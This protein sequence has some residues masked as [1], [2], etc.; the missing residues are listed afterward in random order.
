[1]N[2]LRKHRDQHHRTT[3]G[4]RNVLSDIIPGYTAPMQL[5]SSWSTN[6]KSSSRKRQQL[7]IEEL[8]QQAIAADVAKGTI[9][10]AG[11]GMAIVS[12]KTGKKKRTNVA[13]AGSTTSGPG[14]F[15]TVSTPLTEELQRDLNVL[16]YRNFLDP[17]RFY[18]SSDPIGGTGGT[19]NRTIQVG[20]VIEGVGEYYSDRLSKK[21][22]KGT[23]TE[24]IISSIDK[25]GNNSNST[26]NS[27]LSTNNYVM[28]KYKEGHRTRTALYEKRQ[29]R[30]RQQQKRQHKKKGTKK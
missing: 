5:I 11:A 15:H 27:T 28:N 14:W 3:P 30:Y 18:K 17:K 9:T 13:T 24:E 29:Q 20:T 23:L 12:F 16:R 6:G 19:K 21:Q 8:R 22:R 2:N 7:G 4:T 26:S 1:M 25:G 10:T